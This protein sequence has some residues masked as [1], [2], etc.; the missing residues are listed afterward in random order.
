M[1]ITQ[2]HSNRSIGPVCHSQ[3]QMAI[4]VNIHGNDS[5]RFLP[6]GQNRSGHQISGTI[7]EKD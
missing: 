3:I 2:Q 6:N 7:A 5:V 4:V 1:P